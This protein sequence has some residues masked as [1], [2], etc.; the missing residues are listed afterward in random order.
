MRKIIVT[1]IEHRGEIRIGLNFEK[2]QDWANKVKTI[3]GR[4]WSATKRCWHIPYS[5]SSFEKLKSLFDERQIEIINPKV[6]QHRGEVPPLV[7]A[8][9]NENTRKD[10][11]DQKLYEQAFAKWNDYDTPLSFE[12]YQLGDE[13][14]KKVVGNKIIAKRVDEKWLA[15]FVP[16]DKKK[17]IAVVKNISGRKWVV[18]K[19]Y[20]KVPN[21]KMSFRQLK[22]YI[23]LEYVTFDFK[24]KKE[25][26][27]HYVAPFGKYQKQK[28]TNK[29]KE[30]ELLNEF[31]RSA[32]DKVE[33]QLTLRRYSPSTIKSYKNNLISLFLFFDKSLPEQ[34]GSKEVEAYLLHTIRL[35]K[36]AAS[37]QNQIINAY[38]FFMEKVEGKPKQWVE[39]P[40][41]KRPKQLPNV[42]SEEEIVRLLNALK[43]IKHRLI[44]LM[45]YSGGLR[46]SE[47]VNLKTRDINIDRKSIHIKNAKGQKDRII[48]LGDNVIPFLNSYLEVYQPTEWLFGGQTGGQYSKK[49][50][51]SVF[52][53]AMEKAKITSYAT[54]HTLRHSFA[55]HCIE[56]GYSSSLVQEALGHR[57]IKTTEKYIHLSLAAKR[58]MR[59]PIDRLKLD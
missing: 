8:E 24:I 39:I 30:V 9:E 51:Q 34:I 33:E 2:N 56:N 11:D 44:L 46:L 41:A 57:S 58:K 53:K 19:S 26:P 49:S 31:Q 37:T 5:A 45:I 14:R 17:W 43:N 59:S 18:E 15:L 20:W 3:P 50:V 36:I 22:Q 32:L 16:G 35:K 23:G 54:V 48:V 29:V 55:T 6:K 40:L 1:K 12:D 52:Y 38:K 27:E 28:K 7:K 10:N 42:L 21:V 25:I 13:I 4:K 47:V